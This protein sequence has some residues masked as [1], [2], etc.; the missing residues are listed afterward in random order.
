MEPQTGHI[1]VPCYN[2]E[3]MS[4]MWPR[5]LRRDDGAIFLILDYEHIFID[6][7]SK[8]T[9]SLPHRPPPRIDRR[10]R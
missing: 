5:R 4:R 8:T 9:V 7:A 2:E 10:I 1:V 3:D 6:N